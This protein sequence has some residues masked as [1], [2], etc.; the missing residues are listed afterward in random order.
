MKSL[1]DIVN[2]GINLEEPLVDS[3]SFDHVL[4]VGPEPASWSGLSDEE[5]E[6]K[7][8]VFIC[9]GASELSDKDSLFAATDEF[10]GDPIGIAGRVAFSQEPKPD[11]V[12]FAVNKK[13][14]ATIKE[15]SVIV[16]KTKDE[17]PADLL[18]ELGEGAVTGLPWIIS[19]YKEKD[20]TA[21]RETVVAFTKGT[22]EY[23]AVVTTAVNDVV[24]SSLSIE[25][26]VEG[27]YTVRIEDKTY[28]TA[29]KEILVNESACSMTF[30][31]S[32]DGEI[33][34]N[35]EVVKYERMNEDITITLERA[36][37]TNGWYSIC[38]AYTDKKMIEA[39][40]SWA[41]AQD[42]ICGFT[43]VDVPEDGEIPLCDKSL[44]CYGM[45]AKQSIEQSIES[46]PKDNLYINVAWTIKCLNYHAGSETWAL[47]TLA[48]IQPA[49]LSSTQMRKLEDLNINYYTTCADRDI[50]C[51]GKVT[52]GEWIDVIRFR[53]WLK[54]DMQKSIFDLMLRNPK[55]PYTD[56]GI[57]LVKN[58][59]IASLKRGQ[60]YGGVAETE[61]DADGNEN[62]GFVV[63]VPLA[64]NIT[65]A[66]KK[67]RKLN[68]CKFSARLAGAIHAVDVDGSLIYSNL[69]G[70]A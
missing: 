31:V 51:V 59:M 60:Q 8:S 2:I 68:D 29:A 18:G 33:V 57:G 49:N 9:S 63:S 24:Y 5:H 54:N 70:A 13:L 45:F 44:R 61:F 3:T 1:S 12:Y 19:S 43:V 39:I 66:Q 42:K 26:D 11:K 58:V 15:C 22:G 10:F 14:P 30:E 41:D 47:K 69:G 64:A 27:K 67:S 53:D 48:G 25:N 56:K 35:S 21:H 32:I 65:P 4:I 62:P 40:G 16:A 28:L 6:K 23:D 52:Y 36:L 37:L 50:T 7:E 20:A 17:I 46:V 38:P 55:I 34:R